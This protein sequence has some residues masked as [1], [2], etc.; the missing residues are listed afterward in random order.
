MLEGS[1]RPKSS[2]GYTRRRS[3]KCK[4]EFCAEY[5][6]SNLTNSIVGPL[7][8]LLGERTNKEERYQFDGKQMRAEFHQM[9]DF[10]SAPGDYEGTDVMAH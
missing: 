5:F 8:F 6:I 7:K 1:N 4:A 9:G 3:N 10:E 2:S